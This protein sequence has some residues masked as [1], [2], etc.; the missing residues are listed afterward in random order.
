MS[1][2]L[3]VFFVFA[4]W[5]GAGIA[6]QYEWENFSVT[7]INSEKA[8]ATYIPFE[9]LSWGGNTLENS[10][11]VQVLNGVWKF[12]YFKNPLLVPATIYNRSD[13]AG[14]DD[15]QVPGNWQLQGTGQYDPPVFTN[16]KYPFKPNPPFVPKDYNPTGVY[17]KTFELPSAWHD[18]QLFIHFAGVQSAMYLWVNGKKVGYHED[19]MLP[20]EF[21][22][23]NYVKKGSNELTVQVI[24][25][26]V[27]SYVEDQDFWRL[28]GIYRDVYL[29]ATPNVRMRDFAVFSEL[30]ENFKDAQLHV[31]VDV[32]NLNASLE[33][34]FSIRAILSNMQGESI[35]TLKSENFRLQKNMEK[36]VVLK[37]NIVDPLKWTA[38]IPNLYKVGIELMDENGNTMQAFMVNTGFRKVEIKDGLLLINGKPVKI[39]GVN[40]HE[41]DMYHGRSITRE[42]MIQDILLMKRHN[43]N[44]VRTSHYPNQPEWYNLCDEYGL[45]IMDEAN[46][47]SHGLWENGYHIGEKPEWKQTIVERNVNM[48][49]RDKNHPSIVFWSM[50][51]ESG[52]GENFDTAYAAIKKNDPQKRPVHYESQNPAYAKVL[53]LFDIIS[54]MY[55][56]LSEI[57]R[58][59][60]E[61]TGRPFIICEYA[62]SM[63]NS[64]GNFEKY[65]KLFYKYPRMQ[66]GF[67]WDWI[68][69]GLRSKD[70]NG[71][72]YWNIVNYSDGAN[73]NDGLLTPD[74]RVQPEMNE[75]KYVLQNIAVEPID[76]INGL[77]SVENRNYFISTDNITLEWELLEEGKIVYKSTVEELNI[78]PQTKLLIRLPYPPNTIQAGR[79]YY[80]NLYFVLKQAT[81]WAEKGFQVA[82]EQFRLPL[83][84]DAPA[85]DNNLSS[86][87]DLTVSDKNGVLT[88][89]G[90]RFSLS[91]D[92]QQGTIVSFKSG[93]REML[94]V[95]LL[96]NF[97]RVPTDNDEGGG[98]RSY[99]ARWRQAGLDDFTIA[100]TEFVV[101]A[102]QAK[103][104]T[105]KVVNRLKFKSG[106][107]EQTTRYIVSA[108]GKVRIDNTFHVD[109]QL[110]PLA[111]IGFYT[112][113]PNDFDRVEWYGRGPFESYQD[114][115]SAAF[116]GLWSGKVEEQYFDYV[117]P[118]ENGNKT[119]VRWVEVLSRNASFRFEGLPYLN[120][121]VQNYSDKALNESKTSHTLKRSDKTYIH[122]DYKQ[123]GVGGDDS[124]SPRVHK[125]F[126]LDNKTYRFAFD[127]LIG[128]ADH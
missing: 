12:R 56:P 18:K 107:I 98:Q 116:I 89:S 127:L 7:Q 126:L 40:R 119:D 83:P 122:I 25:W 45:Y 114:R 120:F 77:V 54:Q 62:H 91:F 38:E 29:F 74:R 28:S 6:Q 1:K 82:K 20:A 31:T 109:P 70:K 86:F 90:S 47:E 100:N 93:N 124:W 51:N 15:I 36:T 14:W 108:D 123:M 32:E 41:F 8:H 58:L 87:T 33:G 26:S 81:P 43:I 34:N 35:L 95:P 11:C 16:I 72:P 10:S 3:I 103:K 96:P 30:D 55:L 112:A 22:I 9:S 42:S 102:R 121:N 78:A 75:L 105:V 65:W 66:G 53:S 71:T 106:S 39:K 50:G 118:Q 115:K 69:Q 57:I 23:T 59:F 17:K 110:P 84:V 19:G 64:L 104:V 88:V 68:D 60:N 44:A 48:V 94:A 24:N 63:G 76:A 49:L 99:A 67:T 125:D 52:W 111:R 37:T 128:N 5:A 97:W 73:A 2:K 113:L 27:G 61:D 101:A 79:E 85:E 46:I 4:F 80:L 21:N 92:K 117:M 13:E